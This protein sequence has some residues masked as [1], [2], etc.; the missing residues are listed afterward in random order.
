MSG[1]HRKFVG[2]TSCLTHVLSFY[3]GVFETTDRWKLSTGMLVPHHRILNGKKITESV[4]IQSTRYSR[5][6][7]S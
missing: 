7:F 5:E 6:K 2:G 3:S 4:V 1:G